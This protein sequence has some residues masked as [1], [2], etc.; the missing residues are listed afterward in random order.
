MICSKLF[1]LLASPTLDDLNTLA[2]MVPLAEALMA[3]V[4]SVAAS[5]DSN[6]V[7]TISTV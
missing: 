6:N 3:I 1:I 5:A 2:E 4:A 7:P